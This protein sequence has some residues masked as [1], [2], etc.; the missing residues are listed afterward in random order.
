MCLH[1]SKRL[2]WHLFRGFT[3]AISNTWA[4]KSDGSVQED[5]Q[6]TAP[7]IIGG[8]SVMC[9]FVCTEIWAG[10]SHLCTTSDIGR[11]QKRT[12]VQQEMQTKSRL[13]DLQSEKPYAN[14]PLPPSTTSKHNPSSLKPNR[15]WIANPVIANTVRTNRLQHSQQSKHTPD[16]NVGNPALNV[17][18]QSH[19]ETATNAKRIG[20]KQKIPK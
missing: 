18:K 2:F 19:S 10:N 9:S 11:T 20:G 13:G 15:L 1:A 5:R 12:F 14:K 8:I 4:C 17:L 3:G 6:V 16:E 7:A